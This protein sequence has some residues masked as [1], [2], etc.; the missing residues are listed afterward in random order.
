MSLG[1]WVCVAVAVGVCLG[2]TQSPLLLD[3]RTA[4]LSCRSDG[5]FLSCLRDFGC[6]Q[7]PP[8]DCPSAVAACQSRLRQCLE[9]MAVKDCPLDTPASTSP[10]LPQRSE[11]SGHKKVKCTTAIAICM[12]NSAPYRLCVEDVCQQSP[13]YTPSQTSGHYLGDLS[14]FG[15]SEAE[16]ECGQ[17]VNDCLDFFYPKQNCQY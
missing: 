14:P 2:L 7:T 15:C 9:S 4:L 5:Q 8:D 3:C 16:Y 12:E 10:S 11:R 6:T 1:R 13:S 17:H